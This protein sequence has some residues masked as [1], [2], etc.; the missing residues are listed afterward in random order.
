MDIHS[1]FYYGFILLGAVSAALEGYFLGKRKGFS[2]QE[3]IKYISVALAVGIFSAFLMGRLQTLLISFTELP[4]YNNRMRIF[5]GLLFTPLFMYFPVKYT[6]ADFGR[7]AD[8]LAPGT[9]LLLGFSK[10]GC[11]AFGCCYGIQWEY[12][13]PSRFVPYNVFPVQLLESV[14]CFVIFAVMIF[15][16]AKGKHRKGTVYP[17]SLIL[18][19]VMRFL[20]EYLREYTPAERTYYMGMNFWQMF[21]VISVIAGAVWLTYSCLGNSRDSKNAQIRS[22]E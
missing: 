22:E 5:G 15:I 18:Y 8:L 17:I 13:I 1:V 19:G 14:L 4:N 7:V 9:Y 11:S 16:A 21:S 2:S 20:V 12:G 6:G 3:S 10:L